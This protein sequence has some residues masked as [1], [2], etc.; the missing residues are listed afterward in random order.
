MSQ[1][2]APPYCRNQGLGLPTAREM[3]LYAQ[4]RG[5]DGIGATGN[6]PFRFVEVFDDANIPGRSYKNKEARATQRP[7]Q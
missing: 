2:D 4:A 1:G 3:A 5:A 7:R 6:Y